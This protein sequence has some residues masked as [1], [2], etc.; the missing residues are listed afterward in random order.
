[1]GLSVLAGVFLGVEFPVL[2]GPL[3]CRIFIHY[4]GIDTK[5]VNSRFSSQSPC[6]L[7]Q[8]T[9]DV[10]PTNQYRPRITLMLFDAI[11]L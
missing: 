2:T 3:R 9:R 5:N 11:D 4:S 1:M 10:V 8:V 7:E 6:L